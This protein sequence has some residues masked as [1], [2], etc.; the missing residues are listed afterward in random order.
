MDRAR[1]T[2][3]HYIAPITN[4]HSIVERGILSH[5][6]AQRVDHA[7]IAEQ[8]VQDRR[9][10]KQ[11]PAGGVLHDYANL[12]FDARNPMM[13]ARRAHNLQI[14]VVRVNPA[15]LDIPGT[16]I[17]DGNA[18]SN[19]TRFYPSPAGLAELDENRVYAHSWL[20]DDVWTY[21]ERKRQR[22]SEVLVPQAVPTDYL[23]GCYACTTEV[24]AACR[25]HLVG[26]QVE[27]R[28]DVYF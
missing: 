9:A 2:E 7:S 28:A 10:G 4:L 21:W 3:L 26:L 20:D 13:S 14:A 5:N 12:Y 23:I 11:V 25:T 22:C 6:T 16:V 1:V 8:D 15:A 24:A 17:S 27:V 18:A 19:A